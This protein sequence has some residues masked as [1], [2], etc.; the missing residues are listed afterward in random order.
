MAIRTR[1]TELLE[2]QITFFNQ[3]IETVDRMGFAIK[4]RIQV[5]E[6]NHKN[7]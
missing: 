4:A 6:F 1:Q 2:N 3:C 7:Y 5:E